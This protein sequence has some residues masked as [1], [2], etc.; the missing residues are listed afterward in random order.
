[1]EE[2]KKTETKPS[3]TTPVEEESDFADEA[4]P[5]SAPVEE[6][7]P[8]K[9]AKP[10]APKVNL[11]AEVESPKP[12]EAPAKEKKPEQPVAYTYDDPDLKGIED[13]RLAF[14]ALYKKQNIIKWIVSGS[15]LAIILTMWLLTAFLPYFQSDAGKNLGTYLTLGVVAAAIIAL[16]VYSV[17]FR[18]KLDGAMNDYFAKYYSFN[19]HYV[20]GSRVEGLQGKVDDKLDAAVFNAAGLYK[21]V[22]KVGSRDCLHFTYQGKSV[23]FADCAG[24][25]KGAKS[26]QTCFVGKFLA[27]PNSNDGAE[28]IIYLKGNDRALP[29]TTLGDYDVLE[30]SKTMV[31][32]GPADG[33][34]ILTHAVRQALAQFQTDKTLVDVAIAI[35]RGMTYIALG[36]EDNLMILPLEKPFN[37]APTSELKTN[38]DQTLNFI[39]SLDAKADSK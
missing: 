33:K 39:D 25:I 20:F 14:Y 4:K 11:H 13:A 38:I 31:I 18:K 24:Q 10:D 19:N 22:Y 30:D 15:I 6:V 26:L 27:V 32:Y 21:D 12:E 23:T 36:Y 1:M 35:R 17:V 29:P 34:K 37:P 2:E 3:E 7:K 8:E 5:V 16:G 9:E 28:I